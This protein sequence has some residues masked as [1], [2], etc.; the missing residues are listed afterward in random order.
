MHIHQPIPVTNQSYHQAAHIL[1]KAFKDE[2]VTAAIYRNFSADKRV[3]ALTVDFLAELSVCIRKGNPLEINEEG[4]IVA[5]AVIYPPG[6]YPLSK[7]DQGLILLKSILGN[8]WYDVGSWVKWLNEVD[9]HHPTDPHIY[10]EYLGVEPE[11][12]GKGFGACLLKHLIAKA[13]K[14]GVGCYLENATPRNVSFYQHFGFQV[15]SE[16]DII[17]IPTWFMWRPSGIA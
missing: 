8:G 6:A 7:V 12:Q 3:R 5:A 17:G 4:K 15:V 9:K 1:G 10:L 14:A 13:D 11:Y 2:P 16:M